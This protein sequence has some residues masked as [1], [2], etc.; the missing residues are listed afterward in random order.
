M[1]RC[2]TCCRCWS[3]S[4]GGRC[5]GAPCPP[6]LALA[7]GIVAGFVA[8]KVTAP[9]P[10]A[11]DAEAVQMALRS[12]PFDSGKAKRELGYAPRPIDGP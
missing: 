11:V 9:T 2:A 5:R 1:W 6:A 3:G 8:D 7:T 4:P 10:P 12:A